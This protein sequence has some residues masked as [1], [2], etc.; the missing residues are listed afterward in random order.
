M[1]PFILNKNK[2]RL[3][4]F[5]NTNFD[6]IFGNRRNKIEYTIYHVIIYMYIFGNI[7]E[8]YFAHT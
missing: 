6:S 4:L 5:E 1:L 3:S 7:N 8:F 2:L